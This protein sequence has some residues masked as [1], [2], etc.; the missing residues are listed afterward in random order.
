[1]KSNTRSLQS[2]FSD[3]R[4]T[5][6]VDERVLTV[7]DLAHMFN[8]STKT[9][10]RWRDSGLA[11]GRFAINGRE[12]VGFLKSSVDRFVAQN[13]DR[14]R[15]GASFS[16]LTDDDRAEIVEHA[17][18]LADSGQSRQA[19]LKQIAGSM[20]RS[21][22]TVRSTI[23]RFDKEHPESAVFGN[24]AGTLNAD[25]RSRIYR[26]Y[27]RGATVEE[28]GKTHQRSVAQVHRI[29]NQKRAERIFELPLE[30]VAS[31]EFLDA[32]AE[33]VLLGP[34]PQPEHAPRR[35][36]APSGLPPYLASLY[37]FPLLTK[38]QEVHLFRK[39]NYAKYR[40]SQLREQLD[41]ERPTTR[42][43]A[44]IERLY[45]LAVETKNQIMQTNLRLVVAIVKKR[46]AQAEGFHE[47]ISDGN[48]SLMKAV[49]KFDYT[50]GFKFSTYATWAIKRN[51]AGNYVR[52]MKQ[53]DRYRTGHDEVLDSVPGYRANPYA[54][55]AAQQRHEAVVGKILDC[56]DPRERGIIERRFGL[57]S[58]KE[59]QTLQEIGD[60]LRVSKERVR[61]IETRAI[62]KL[63]EAIG[64]RRLDALVGSLS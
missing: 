21:V 28:L 36:L 2:Q 26:Q 40:A 50:R 56:L 8:V 43:L 42:L 38:E 63:R 18:L 34:M 46:G 6:P 16:Q 25:L 51:S 14:I 45:R 33:T 9:V 62:G 52:Q 11:G 12:R 27:C 17:R 61:Q 58:V 19:V 20:K 64:E 13:P 4:F 55:E 23:R 41:P 5:E 7:D 44:E 47:R 35:V 1:M 39:Y 15:R 48:I 57:G 3:P 37:E 53:A 22:E 49:E 60:D 29:I 30:Y 54:E 59:P 32:D 24:A 31:A 10:T